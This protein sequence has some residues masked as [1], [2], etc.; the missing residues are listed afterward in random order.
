M[1]GGKRDHPRDP[2]DLSP[3]ARRLYDEIVQDYDLSP[4]ERQAL[5]GGLVAL[6]QAIA[7]ERV[8][9]KEGPVVVDRFGQAQRHPAAVMGRDL[10]REFV[11]TLT[12]LG[13]ATKYAE[14]DR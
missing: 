4:A 1:S 7:C 11:Q 6:D 3:E 5:I 2:S 9:A 12:T 10:R 8:V 14:G 13:L